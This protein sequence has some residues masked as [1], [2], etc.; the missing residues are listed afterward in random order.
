MTTVVIG[1]DAT[2][3]DFNTLPL[4]WRSSDGV[5]WTQFVPPFNPP[6]NWFPSQDDVWFDDG[7][8]RT[9]TTDDHGNLVFDGEPTLLWFSSDYS[10]GRGSGT[11]Y[12][13]E[14]GCQTWQASSYQL[15]YN[16]SSLTDDHFVGHGSTVRFY[17]QIGNYGSDLVACYGDV[18]SP[19]IRMGVAVIQGDPDFIVSGL[20]SDPISSWATRTLPVPPAA[21]AIAIAADA[22]QI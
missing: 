20:A 10:Q 21:I 12:Q 19:P 6:T 9:T 2:D 3:A 22:L 1:G 7:A 17:G 14:D 5:T 15:G 13:S 11:L 8:Q 16:G 18:G 4:Y